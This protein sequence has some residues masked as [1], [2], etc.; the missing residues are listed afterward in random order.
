MIFLIPSENGPKGVEV[1]IHL[2]WPAAMARGLESKWI[3]LVLTLCRAVIETSAPSLFS[4]PRFW[5]WPTFQLI[6]KALVFSED[7][8]RH[9]GGLR[10]Q[11]VCWSVVCLRWQNW[12][13][14]LSCYPWCSHQSII[15]YIYIII[16]IFFDFLGDIDLRRHDGGGLVSPDALEVAV[17][18]LGARK[19]IVSSM[20]LMRAG[21]IDWKVIVISI[22]TS[23]L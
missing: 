10:F 3:K 16:Y 18:W 20:A 4:P 14:T 2:V 23:A 17:T 7:W 8:C 21:I 1:K 19:L 6:P 11:C 15:S 22:C 5:R 9:F 13:D 12:A